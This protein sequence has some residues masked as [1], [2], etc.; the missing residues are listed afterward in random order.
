MKTSSLLSALGDMLK[1]E[2]KV[3]SCK[4]LNY[5]AEKSLVILHVTTQVGVN[6]M[7]GSC[8]NIDRNYTATNPKVTALPPLEIMFD[9]AFIS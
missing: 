6:G 5:R 8:D 4:L 1:V 2:R 7:K 9:Y 3:L